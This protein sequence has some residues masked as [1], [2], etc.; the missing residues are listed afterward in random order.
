MYFMKNYFL[1]LLFTVITAVTSL[2]Q[3]NPL[4]L[5]YPA[6][7]PDGSEIAFSYKGDIYRVSTS[8]GQAVPLT[9][10]E[11]H[12]FMPVWSP[13]GKSI[14][15]ASDRFGNFDVFVMPA[16]GGEAKRLT[17]HSANDF[18]W[19]FSVDGKSVLF[20]SP[21]MDLNTSLRFP[22][23]PLFNKLYT[24]SV[25]G[26]R[27]LLISTAGFQNARFDSKG[28]RIIFQD[29][30][31]YENE[32]RKHH[33]SSVTRDI[34]IYD[35]KAEK[36]TKVSDFEGEDRDPYFSSDGNSFYYLSEKKGHQNIFKR[37]V[38]QPNNETQLTNFSDHPVRHLSR[39]KN[40]VLCFTWKGEIYTLKEGD[41][42]K[43]VSIQIGADTRGNE[44]KIVP[45]SSGAT[46]MALSPNG[47]EIAF[48]FRGEVFVTAVEGGMTKRVT[49]TP[50][51]ERM[52]SWAKD[53]RSLYYSTER[54]PSWD[55]YRSTLVRPEELYFYTSTLLKEE[56]VIASD[57]EEFQGIISPDG[58]EMAYLE[59]RN[60][61][62]IWN[63][64]NRTAR[65]IIPS[66]QNFSYVDGDQ[67]FAWSPDGK[68]IVARNS[69]G[70]YG[71]NNIL[72]Y[73]A[74]K[75]GEGTNLTNSGFFSGGPQW[76]MDGKAMLWVSDRDGK[77]PLA[78]S[79]AREVDVYAM[80]FDKEAYDRFRLSKDEFA[81]LKEKEEKAK[82]AEPETP[83]TPEKSSSKSKS[84]VKPDIAKSTLDLTNLDSRKLRLTTGSLNLSGYRLSS[85]GEKLYFMARFEQGFDVWSL[86]TRTR[87]LKSLAKTN[88]G[89]G[90]LELSADGKSLFVLANNRIQKIDTEGGKLTPITIDAEMVLNTAG[91]REY[92][93]HH[94]WRQVKKKFYD[95][96]LHGIN[97][98]MYR[99]TYAAFLPHVNNNYDFQELLSELLGELNGSHTGANLNINA[100]QGDITAS[101]GLFYDEKSTA[102]G[103]KITEVLPEGPLDKAVSSVRAGNIIER[104]D[105][106][107]ITPATDWNMLLNRKAG[108]NVLLSI[109]DGT[110][111][112]EEIVKPI[113]QAEEN[114]LLYK[115]WIRKMNDLTAKLSNGRIGYVHVQGM[116]D[117]SFRH[118]YEEV[119]GRH[120]E[121]D[122]LI[123]DTRFNGGGWLHEDLSNFL[124]GK[125]YFTFKPFGLPATGSDPR[126]KWTKPSAVLM[127]E[128]NYS[129][130]FLFP[131]A[132]KHKGIG[133]L[134]GMPVPGTG[135]AVWW[136]T[137]IDPTLVFGIPM[138]GIVGVNEKRTLE[139]LQLDPDIR[140][141]SP[142]ESVLFGTDK[143][144]ERAIEE[145]IRDLK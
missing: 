86:D 24:V 109:Y 85:N 47:K 29:R 65:V 16:Q 5:R 21:R 91:E 41:Q 108:K 103:L 7:S 33:T 26:G 42:P 72:L 137:Q 28:E 37:S 111:R 90:S 12:D 10:H 136:E 141:E 144:L 114:T 22:N 53:G 62:K 118:V 117:G 31:G 129:D 133:K 74:Q 13:D 20:S 6:I 96:K 122:A 77:Q 55:I 40:N 128:S 132:Y 58:T 76:A 17:T 64:A 97:W 131:Y 14:A 92:I 50:A 145:L 52:L 98:E 106:I 3:I 46:E 119:L 105:G 59:E 11:A 93:Y 139:N 140:I 39:S 44:P 130:A 102:A 35:V 27:N 99:D 69:M 87:E 121:K 104:V 70:R 4:W 84:P 15:F 79:G 127:S 30:K 60:T 71:S 61:L 135:T 107:E 36:F 120:A 57:K 25:E 9:L 34:W 1:S 23:K 83:K 32:F 115:R 134:I 116:N 88:S 45:I 81:L 54:G 51:Q 18:P 80:F 43:K 113:T 100:P 124:D 142:Y 38:T 56:P 73:D 94:A 78:Y 19:D 125:T 49:N 48:I 63:F 112:W 110:R 126:D 95:P 123:V 143:Q 138:I 2:S 66:G 101:L 8:G 82:T 67:S 89:G 68:W 75:G